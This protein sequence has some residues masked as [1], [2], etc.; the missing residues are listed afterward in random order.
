MVSHAIIRRSMKTLPQ[1][2][3]RAVIAS[4]QAIFMRGLAALVLAMKN[5]QLVG[6]ARSVVEVV[7]LIQMTEPDLVLLDFKNSAEQARQ[8]VCQIHKLWPAIKIVLLIETPEETLGQDEFDAIPLYLFSRDVSEDEFKAALTQVERD[9]SKKPRRESA[10][11]PV[12]PHHASDESDSEVEAAFQI[13]IKSRKGQSEEIMTRELVMAGKIQADILPEEAPVL[14]GWDIATRLEPARETSGDFYDFIP[15]T[16]HKMGIVVADVSDKGMGAALF[17]ALSSSLFRTYAT[18]FPTL[19]GLTMSAVS[20][21]IL[22]DTR[23]NMFVT[24]FF[25]ILEPFTGRLI[26]ANAGHPPGFIISNARGKTSIEAL[27]TTGMALGV[28]EEARWT[29]KIARMVPGDIL[30]LYTDGITEAQNMAGQFF[31][32]DRILDVVLS[33]PAGTARHIMNLLLDEVHHFV[34]PA[35]RQDDIA[36][37]VVK[38]EK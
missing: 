11:H 15:L 16:D 26:F 22:S 12:F 17:M 19:P 2:Q 14:P 4:D 24:A 36:L 5:V 20:E 30:L 32:E 6:E 1:T 23:G 35:R 29:Q 10:A 7:E 8:I 33:R 31:G 27:R 25:G 28:S 21:R 37:I 13:A 3:T 38:R 18:R 9:I 34:G